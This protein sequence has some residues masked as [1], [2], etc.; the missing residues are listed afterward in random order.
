[1]SKIK[2]ESTTACPQTPLFAVEPPTPEGHLEDLPHALR[3]ALVDTMKPL[4]LSRWQIAGRC[5]EL[6]GREV[7]KAMLDAY[8]AESHE[9]H[10]LPA[11]VAVAISVIAGNVQ[12]LD[13][14]A[15]RARCVIVPLAEVLDTDQTEDLRAGLLHCV[16]E[17]GEAAQCLEESLADGALT[18]A[19]LL[20]FRRELRDVIKAACAVAARIEEAV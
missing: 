7:S 12:V 4:A 14:M 10:R 2:K 17:L 20:R 1:M 19:E 18:R 16:R 3:A 11:D 8:C 9:G 5:S 13:V 6:L 15:Q